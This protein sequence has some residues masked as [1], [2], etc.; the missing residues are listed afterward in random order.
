MYWFD[1]I[2]DE[3]EDRGVVFLIGKVKNKRNKEYE[4]CLLEIKNIKRE[5]FIIGN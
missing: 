2:E 3:N 1:A 5:Y 4:T